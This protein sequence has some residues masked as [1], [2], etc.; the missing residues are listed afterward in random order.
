MNI[1]ILDG[2]LSN[3]PTEWENY[4]KGLTITLENNHHIV[5][6]IKLIEKDLSQCTGCF[7]CWVQTPGICIIKDDNQSI[8]R[9]I[10][11]S[12]LV[13][14]ASPLIM[15]FVSSV[16]KKKM[17]RMIP[18]VHPYLVV[19][20][21]EIHH[22]S[23]YERYPLFGLLVQ[24]EEEDT[25]NSLTIVSHLFSRTVRN[26]KS[27]LIFSATTFEPVQKIVEKIENVSRSIESVKPKFQTRQLEKVGKL[28]SL[29]VF[30]G[31]PRGR[32]GNTPILLQKIMEGFTRRQG[33]TAEMI[34]LFEV[35]KR[36][37]FAHAFKNAQCVMIGFPL[38]TDGMPGIVK[39]FIEDLQLFMKRK[40]NPPMAFLVQSG[41]PEAL[42][43]RHVQQYLISLADRLRSPY[44]GTLIRG[45]C[46]G[47]RLMPEKYNRRMFDIL[48]AVGTQLSNQGGFE[49]TSIDKFSSIEQF[50]K[51]LIPLISLLEK[52]FLMQGYWNNQLKENM[53]FADRFA[54]PYSEIENFYSM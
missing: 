14:F 53:V 17:D 50:P 40:D 23:R 30:N 2:A 27:K 38:Y 34:H 24:P 39:E 31:S 4:L 45:G 8:N 10:I 42:H 51:V 9:T 26:I 43:S 15:G 32:D 12:D 1:T 19:E 54:K 5:N 33:N 46:E 6:R 16:L 18:L 44:L 21:G 29:T 41:F 7:K 13:L 22:L 28:N 20:H 3:T 48:N 49:K 11:N 36:T 52:T 37:E 35:E 47:V 25:E